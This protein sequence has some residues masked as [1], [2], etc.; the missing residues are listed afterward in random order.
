MKAPETIQMVEV[1]QII[2][3]EQ[4]NMINRK[5]VNNIGEK[6]G[7]EKRRIGN[8]YS[9]VKNGLLSIKKRGK[10]ITNSIIR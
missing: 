9:K 6:E 5:C 4:R 8:I 1:K 7:I 10:N 3:F 2:T